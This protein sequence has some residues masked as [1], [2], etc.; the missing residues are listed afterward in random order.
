MLSRWCYGLRK[1]YRRWWEVIV[2]DLDA[3]RL[4]K[5]LEVNAVPD[6]NAVEDAQVAP[7]M[8]RYSVC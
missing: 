2:C 7:A 6:L 5:M 1:V 8:R 4:K 3:V